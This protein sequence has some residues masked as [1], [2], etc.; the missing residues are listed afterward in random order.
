MLRHFTWQKGPPTI[1]RLRLL[2]C[3]FVVLAGPG[4]DDAN[5]RAT[6]RSR[7]RTTARD[8]A[9]QLAGRPPGQN[10]LIRPGGEFG[11]RYRAD[12]EG[13]VSLVVF[14]PHRSPVAPGDDTMATPGAALG[15]DRIEEALPG[16]Q[17]IAGEHLSNGPL[18]R[19]GQLVLPVLPASLS[20][21]AWTRRVYTQLASG[22]VVLVDARVFAPQGERP[23]FVSPLTAGE[24]DI[25]IETG[26]IE[27]HL[28][29]G[30]PDSALRSW[31]SVRRQ[32]Q[33][34]ERWLRM[35]EQ[36]GALRPAGLLDRLHATIAGQREE[37]ARLRQQIAARYP[38]QITQLTRSRAALVI[39]RALEEVRVHHH[40][41]GAA[42]SG[43]VA[44]END[45]GPPVEV[46]A[47]LA[48]LE[49]DEL[50]WFSPRTSSYF[51]TRTGRLALRQLEATQRRSAY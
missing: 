10:A 32:L 21:V 5:A 1:H 34:G 41:A 45:S 37:L 24:F 30:A 19:D 23:T 20:G 16:L 33:Q 27:A 38:R 12:P 44:A 3:V 40:G 9:R 42:L 28:A 11:L 35:A 36:I 46:T 17:A 47:V 29:R 15:A 2:L 6:R 39:L 26:P 43:Y 48:A 18:T 8:L 13:P 7:L 50:V 51:L 49:H 31:R 25:A 14:S 22:R 4:H